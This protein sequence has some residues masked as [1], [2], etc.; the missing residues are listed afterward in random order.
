M[1]NKAVVIILVLPQKRSHGEL[2]RSTKLK[3]V[4][5]RPP[6]LVH[7]SNTLSEREVYY[8]SRNGRPTYGGLILVLMC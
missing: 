4:P 5:T 7:V 6:N 3:L 8:R 1:A 2:D